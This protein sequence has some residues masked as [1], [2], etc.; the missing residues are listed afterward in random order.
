MR[1]FIGLLLTLAFLAACDS[2]V[3]PSIPI[4]TAAQPVSSLPSFDPIARVLATLTKPGT[5]YEP[6][7][8]FPLQPQ[9]VPCSLPIYTPPNLNGSGGETIAAM[10][11][12]SVQATADKWVVSFTQ[13]WNPNDFR[14]GGDS[15]SGPF[16]HTWEF[17][18][19]QAGTIQS[20]RHFGQFPPQY[21]HTP[22]A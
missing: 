21:V 8:A 2:A 7:T 9:T 16:Q 5:E 1:L 20:R 13:T 10:C 6:I 17:T 11:T 4:P 19:D 18:L 12:T 15:G 3:A 22:F 14:D